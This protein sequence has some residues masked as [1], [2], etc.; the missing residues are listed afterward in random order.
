MD[1]LM[2]KAR[3]SAGDLIVESLIYLTTYLVILVCLYPFIYVLSMS[4]S[5]P[6]HV[7]DGS[8]WL[9]PRGFVLGSYKRLFQNPI[10]WLHYYNTIFYTVVGT[11]IAVVVTCMAAY[12]LSRPKFFLKTPMMVMIVMTM[13][14]S[15]GLIP[16]FI[17]IN[18]LGMYNTRWAILLPA[19]ASTFLVI[20]ARTFFQGISEELHESAKLDGANDIQVLTR[21]VV[22]LSK[23][24]L[25]V[26]ALFY[27][28]NHWNSFFPAMLYLPDANLQPISL[29]LIKIVMR[30]SKDLLNDVPS[31]AME[32][33]S[34]QLKY[35]V[36]MVVVTPILFI[37]PFMQK[38]F[39]KGVMIGSLKG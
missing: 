39:V 27:A 29:Y 31:Q 8:V 14:F 2:A 35:S 16:L 32:A 19:A 4:F 28:V 36:I 17:L 6:K 1:P 21:I 7:L 23:P 25:A 9:Y 20:V 38:H 33:L 15:G 12:P 10:I 13:F 3:K 5:A 37:Y 18:K 24:I 11:A 30:D 34:I 22:P 26:L